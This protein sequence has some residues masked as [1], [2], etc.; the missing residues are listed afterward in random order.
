MSGWINYSGIVISQKMIEKEIGYRGS[1]SKS[2]TL[3]VKEQRVDGSCI[4]NLC[5]KNKIPMLRYTLTGFERNYQI[6]IL[7]NQ[8]NQIRTYSANNKSQKPIVNGRI[9]PGFLTGFS[10]AEGTFS[11]LIQHNKNYATNWRVKAIFAIGL[12]SKD[13]ALLETIK[14]YLGVGN[15]HKHGINS[16]QYRV[17]S[18]K[19]LQV[20]I[21][22]FDKYPLVTCKNSDYEI[23]KKAFDIIKKQEHTTKEGLLKLVGLKSSLNLGLTSKLKEGFSNWK[24]I[25]ISRPEYNFKGIP[26]PL[27]MAGFSSGDSSFNIKISK[28]VTSKLGV[29]VQLRFSIGLHLREKEFVKYLSTYFNLTKDKNVYYGENSVSFQVTNTNDI[30]N[31]IIPFFMKYPIKGNKSLDFIEFNKVVIMI[32]NKEHLTKEGFNEILSIKSNMNQ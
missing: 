3:F 15:I 12:H 19:D 4:G 21:D 5:I 17:E 14:S 31:V 8:I 20:I 30:T 11:I 6:K 23:F 25:E 10:D 1:K 2:N 18:I 26:D 24:D 9:D 29:R 7:S 27:W 28:S 16:L 13:V 22:H 32:N